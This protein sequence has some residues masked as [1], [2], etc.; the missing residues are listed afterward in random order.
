[1][2]FAAADPMEWVHCHI[3]RQPAPPGEHVPD[4]PLAVSNIVMKLL[5]KA[6]EDRYQTAAGVERDL[7]H[8]LAEWEARGWLDDLYFV[9]HAGQCSVEMILVGIDDPCRTT[10]RTRQHWEQWDDSGPAGLV[11]GA[12]AGSVIPVEILVKQNQIMPTG[13]PLEFFSAA[14]ERAPFVLLAAKDR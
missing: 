12:N 9:P 13:I 14:M 6:A 8:C 10:G 2:P 11:A 4:L 3:A 7:R 1:L 5:A